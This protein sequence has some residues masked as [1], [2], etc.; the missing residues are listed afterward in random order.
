MK[1][2]DQFLILCENLRHLRKA[3]GFF[4]TKMARVL[5]ISVK[6]L[7]ELERDTLPPRLG[8]EA[9]W[10][11]SDYFQVPLHTLFDTMLP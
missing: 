6:T 9:L 1:S 4:K 8:C 7:N 11:T 3:N 10:R 5:G 2:E